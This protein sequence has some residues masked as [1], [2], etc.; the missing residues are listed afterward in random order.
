MDDPLP[1]DPATLARLEAYAA[2]PRGNRSA[3]TWTVDELLTL[4]DPTVPVTAI[5]DRLGVKRA[6]V[7]YE[8]V[9][10]RRAGFPVPDRP[11]GGARSP[12]TIAIEDDL[13]A[14]MSDAEA[15]RRHGV[16][17]VRV[18]QVRVRAGLPTTRRLWTEG[19][20][21]VLIAHQ[22]RPTRDVAE[23]VGRPVRAVDAERLQLIAEGRIT[24][25]IVRTRKRAD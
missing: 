5:M 15:A 4:F 20:R 9:R 2:T 22:D 1:L 19:D 8:L 16:S 10:L 21:E 13:R 17:P 25:K 18:Q 23:M 14:G 24:P 11:S 3:R 7:T 6:V 12:R